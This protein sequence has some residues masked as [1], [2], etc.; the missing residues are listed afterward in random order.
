[1]DDS[2]LERLRDICRRHPGKHDCFLH[3]VLPNLSETVVYLGNASKINIS[4][5]LKED[6]ERLLGNGSTRFH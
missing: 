4:Q 5:L 6:V 1:M 3:L 2:H